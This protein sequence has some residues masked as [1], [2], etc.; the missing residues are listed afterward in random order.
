MIERRDTRPYSA[1]SKLMSSLSPVQRRVAV[2]LFSDNA[3]PDFSSPPN[4]NSSYARSHILYQ[5]G[6]PG[7]KRDWDAIAKATGGYSV[8]AKTDQFTEIE[9]LLGDLD[10]YYLLGYVPDAKTLEMGKM[11]IQTTSGPREVTRTTMHSLKVKSRTGGIEVRASDKFSSSGLVRE[12]YL[13]AAARNR[14]PNINSGIVANSLPRIT[15]T[16]TPFI[17]GSLNITT[18]AVPLFSPKEEN[19]IRVTLHLE[20]NS[21]DFRPDRNSDSRIADITI[22]GS[23]SLEGR[24]VNNYRGNATFLAPEQTSAQSESGVYTTTFDIPAPAPGLYELRTMALQSLGGR[25]GNESILIEVPDFKRIGLVASGIST[26]NL[27]QSPGIGG[28]E[29]PTTRKIHRSDPFVCSLYV[30]N[31]QRDK[32]DGSPK[33]ESQFRLYRDDQ[34]VEAS[35]VMSLLHGDPLSN[36]IPIK[37]NIDPGPEMTTGNYL[38]EVLVVDQLAGKNNTAAQSVVIELVE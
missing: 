31:A 3:S 14:N 1:V 38:L 2:I 16:S 33:I 32:S 37:F 34:L 18:E 28:G 21:L 24:T 22:T 10:Q 11:T 19:I 27:A 7:W 29:Q 12:E 36:G 9:Q 4:F 8:K 17:S 30:Y 15:I 23:L 35:E 5:A 13:S 26:F 20:G 6:L 25:F